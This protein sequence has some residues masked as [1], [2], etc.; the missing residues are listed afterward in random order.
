MALAAVGTGWH[1]NNRDLGP[2]VSSSG[3]R[4]WSS[5]PCDISEDAKD[6]VM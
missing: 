3:N 2:C 6:K 5:D 4:L 1:I